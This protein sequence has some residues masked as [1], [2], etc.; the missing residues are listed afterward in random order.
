MLCCDHIGQRHCS[1]PILFFCQCCLGGCL[2][3]QQ[4]EMRAAGA[5]LVV[6]PPCFQAS[7]ANLANSS[8]QVCQAGTLHGITYSE[9]AKA[10]SPSKQSGAGLLR[11]TSEWPCA[12]WPKSG[13]GTLDIVHFGMTICVNI[14]HAELGPSHCLHRL[15]YAHGC[16]C[17]CAREVHW[18]HSG[19]FLSCTL[20]ALWSALAL[21]S[22]CVHV[23]GASSCKLHVCRL[24]MDA[25]AG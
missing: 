1:L 21:Y 23:C 12:H 9:S 22:V 8:L 4:H 6:S 11:V 7:A 5:S 18:G 24:Y 10:S 3:Q 15:V 20:G 14:P 2:P 25:A 16:K 19:V 17:W 13:Y